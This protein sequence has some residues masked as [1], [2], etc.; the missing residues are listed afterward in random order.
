MPVWQ[1]FFKMKTCSTKIHPHHIPLQSIHQSLVIRMDLALQV[2]PHDV[3]PF[4]EHPNSGAMV[5]NGILHGKPVVVK[6]IPI[7]D[8][9][10]AKNEAEVMRQSRYIFTV[11]FIGFYICTDCYNIVLGREP[12]DLQF[13]FGEISGSTRLTLADD[14]NV[15]IMYIIAQ[16][17]LGLEHLHSIGVS[18]RDLKAGNLVI[19]QNGIVKFIDFGTATCFRGGTDATAGVGQCRSFS[20]HM[21]CLASIN[22]SCPSMPRRFR[23]QHGT[24]VQKRTG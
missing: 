15:L 16:I 11:P 4:Y 8:L 18:H 6:T 23:L 7:K 21:P 19:S 9:R 14:F 12:T 10:A 13:V 17:A 2:T 24:R 22:G 1:P 20:E 5:G 3:V